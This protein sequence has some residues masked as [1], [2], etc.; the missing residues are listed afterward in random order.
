MKTSSKSHD[1]GFDS[2][3]LLAAWLVLFNHSYPLSGIAGVDAVTLW[4][5]I[6]T[7][8]GL[9]VSIFFALSGYLVTISLQNCQSYFDY[10]RRR[11]VRIY[12][13]LITLCL[14]S[15]FI[16]GPL[17]TSL[18]LISFF[19][20]DATWQYL[21]TA[22]GFHIVFQLPGIFEGNPV[23]YV[24]N[25]SLWSLAYELKCYV[26]LALLAILPCKLQHK[27]WIIVIVLIWLFAFRPT[28]IPIHVTEKFWGLDYYE[29]R[30]SIVFFVSALIA[31]YRK[32]LSEKN[33]YLLAIVSLCG[34]LASWASHY[35]VL[36]Q[37]LYFISL[38]IAIL[39][40]AL[41]C[42]L[43]PRIPKEIGDLSYGVYLYGFPVQQILAFHHVQD[44]GIV[45]YTLMSTLGAG[46]L[47]ACSWHLIEKHTLQWKYSKIMTQPEFH[48]A[49]TAK[50]LTG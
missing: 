43:I 37:L 25:G 49:E 46:I 8:G 7:S 50:E 42:K 13:A 35:G 23:F 34:L 30:L 48:H 15:V 45:W 18:P 21:I 40:F 2:L 31:T 33:W 5:K 28:A 38:P 32:T 19:T 17:Y 24:V 9:G 4:L 12:P 3:R 39:W 1:N 16:I 11:V 44:Y 29:N 14:L 26:V 22:S 20:D 47:A 36:S 27:L 10:F 41:H 6:D